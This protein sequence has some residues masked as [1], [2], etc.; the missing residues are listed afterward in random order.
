MVPRYLDG[1]PREGR[2]NRKALQQEK[3]K[4]DLRLKDEGRILGVVERTRSGS[5]NNLGWAANG[6]RGGS[7][8]IQ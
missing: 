1:N 5:C 2:G 7:S 4:G 6:G 3:S 8:P